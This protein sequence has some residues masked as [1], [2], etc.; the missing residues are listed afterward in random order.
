LAQRAEGKECPVLLR[1]PTYICDFYE[2]RV[3]G[4]KAG[5]KHHI[6]C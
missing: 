3:G 4:P 5:S 6:S 1:A 2:G